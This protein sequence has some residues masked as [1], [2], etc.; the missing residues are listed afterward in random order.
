MLKKIKIYKLSIVG[1]TIIFIVILL[2]LTI[3]A[4]YETDN[5]EWFSV[6][7]DK[8]DHVISAYGALI[9]G[10]LAFLSILFII[11]Q[12]LEQRE[13]II[14]EKKNI[15]KDK[16]EEQRDIIKLISS[17]LGSIIGDIKYQG[18][19]LTTFYEKELLNPTLSNQAYFTVND[20]F[21]RIIEMD[22]I[23]VYRSF[24]YFFKDEKDWEKKFLNFYRNIDFYLKITPHLREKYTSQIDE[25]VKKKYAIQSS[26]QLFLKDL[27]KIRNKYIS[28]YPV[29]PFNLFGFPYFK[30]LTDFWLEYR[31]YISYITNR[32]NHSPI[33]SD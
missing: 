1:I 26:I 10:I 16:I 15:E 18:Q 30:V 32:V 2:I 19:V 6:D 3:D 28:T 11:Y 25:K 13:Q 21:N 31:N 23:T 5:W 24:R 20:N 8:R 27:H 12:V 7:F 4:I 33:D 22:Y 29:P 17:F 9:G 14:L